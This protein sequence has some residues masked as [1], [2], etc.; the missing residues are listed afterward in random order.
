VDGARR[1]LGLGSTDPQDGRRVLLTVRLEKWRWRRLEAG[2]T[3]KQSGCS[4]QNSE[5]L[6]WQW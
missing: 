1:V 6:D 2:C 5:Q 3:R 4:V